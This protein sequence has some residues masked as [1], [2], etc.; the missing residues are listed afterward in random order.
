V[1]PSNR[2]W[3]LDHA[4]YVRIFAAVVTVSQVI[5]LWS[6]ACET[7]SSGDEL[8]SFVGK[9]TSDPAVDERGG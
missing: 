7:V 4:K 3:A 9:Q 8:L 2:L 5:A 6:Q 1:C